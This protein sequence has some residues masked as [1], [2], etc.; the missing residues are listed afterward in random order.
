MSDFEARL[1]KFLYLNSES[2][3]FTALSQDAST[4]EYFRI[5]R[6]GR[7]A[8][9]CVYPEAFVAAEHNYIDV[10]RLFLAGG[11]PVAE[12]LLV[13]EGLGIIVLEDLG[14]TILRDVLAEA[15]EATRD[16]LFDAAIALIAR[17]QAAT[18]LAIQTG[19]VASRL[20]FD[21]EKLHWELGFF[22]THFFETYRKRPLG[23]AAS[24]AAEAEFREISRELES[25]ARVLC[26]RDFHAAN[27]MVAPDGRLRIIDH[28]DARIGSVSY[29]LVSL[30]LDRVTNPPPAG[31]IAAK[32][33]KLLAEREMQG[34]AAID[35]GEFAAE[36]RLQSIQRC[37]KAVGTFSYQS[38]VR[39]KTY[40]IRYIRPMLEIANLAI[41]ET[42][43]FRILE[44]ILSEELSENNERNVSDL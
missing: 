22:K 25:V 14:N 39:G 11:L 29:D 5:T 15:A 38:A 32:Q 6:Q 9:A 36:F 12:I 35:V 30:L 21:E 16:E 17:I 27:L 20:Q 34:L 40:F 1:V 19:S 7:E 23:R 3:K 8:I 31:W 37:L 42:G 41:R 43:R 26:H 2:A 33:A 24:A 4:R 10:T 18:P 28:Q 44:Q 13:D